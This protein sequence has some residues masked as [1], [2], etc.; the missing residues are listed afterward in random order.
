MK[1]GSVCSGVEAAT[2]AWEPLGWK[3]QFFSEIEPFPCDVLKERWPN[4]PNEGD[5]TKRSH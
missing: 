4:V 2:L 3:A 5:F 1:Y